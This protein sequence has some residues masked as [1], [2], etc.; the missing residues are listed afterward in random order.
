MHW[1]FVIVADRICYPKVFQHFGF[2]WLCLTAADMKGV[3]VMFDSDGLYI[4]D[5]MYSPSALNMTGTP[6]KSAAV[7]QQQTQQ[8]HS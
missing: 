1:A 3:P 5:L 2:L 8:T 7:H 4:P 6:F